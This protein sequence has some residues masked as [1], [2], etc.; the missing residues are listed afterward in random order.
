MT[1]NE[2]ALPASWPSL[3]AERGFGTQTSTVTLFGGEAPHNINDHES[4]CAGGLLTS[5]TGSIAQ[6]GQ[7]VLQNPVTARGGGQ[8]LNIQHAAGID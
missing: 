4:T 2:A 3:R 6:I 1:E 5:I 7:N 8:Q